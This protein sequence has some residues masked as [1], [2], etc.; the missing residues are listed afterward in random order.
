ML[1]GEAKEIMV[2]MYILLAI[3]MRQYQ[4]SECFTIREK[5]LDTMMGVESS[6]SDYQ[7]S[8]GETGF[9]MWQSELGSSKTLPQI[10]TVFV[11]ITDEHSSRNPVM[12]YRIRS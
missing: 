7:L 1:R 11:P 4:L 9:S 3:F 10:H 12:V 2:D 8:P 6:E 5:F